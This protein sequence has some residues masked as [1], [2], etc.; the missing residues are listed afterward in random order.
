MGRTREKT[1]KQRRDAVEIIET[2]VASALA[3]IRYADEPSY[4]G[5]FS[6]EEICDRLG[7][8][9]KN[10]RYIIKDCIAS[11]TCE[12]AG[13]RRGTGIDG[14]VT[15]TPVYR[16]KFKNKKESRKRKR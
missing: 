12:Y 11:G 2:D 5:C 13:K 4:E 9:E 8:S 7:E 1:S 16:F 3:E 10:A 14:R 6:V 15:R